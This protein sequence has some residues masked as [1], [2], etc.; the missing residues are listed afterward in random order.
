MGSNGK[1]AYGLFI[2]NI[3]WILNFLVMIMVFVIIYDKF[4]EVYSGKEYL[5]IYKW[6]SEASRKMAM[7]V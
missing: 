4:T 3:A 1:F 6:L 7:Y 2:G 5:N